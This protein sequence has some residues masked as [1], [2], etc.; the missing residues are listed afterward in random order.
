[1]ILLKDCARCGGDLLVVTFEGEQTATCFQCGYVRIL[2]GGRRG[3]PE[4]RRR[5]RA[6]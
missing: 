3:V 1:M 5:G 4:E 6:R 2:A